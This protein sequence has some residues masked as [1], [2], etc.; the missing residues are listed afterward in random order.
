M[1]LVPSFVAASFAI[2]GL[3]A[4]AGP[5]II[6]L[7]N[8]RRYRIVHWAAMDFLREAL[9]RNRRILTLRDLLLLL[10]RTLAVLLVGLAL[11]RPFFSSS[12]QTY[13]RSK[14][15][16]AVLVVDNS[17]SMGY[18]SIEG[19]L[20]DR[21]KERARQF[22]DKLPADS[23][24]TI[25]P[26]CGS[27]SGYSPDAA[28]KENALQSLNKIELVDRSASVLRAMNE[29]KKACD[30][31]PTL[32][33]RIVIFSDQQIS[34]WRRLDSARSVP[35]DAADSGRGRFRDGPAEHVDLQLP[36]PRRRRGRR[37]ADDVP[38]R[39]PLRRHG[40]RADV[41]VQLSVDEQQVGSKTVTL[42]P[43]QG[44]REV[45]FQYLFNA[46]QPEPG[47]SLPVPVKVSLTPDNL[48]ADDE[49]CLVVPVVAALPVVFVDQF[50]EEEEDPVKNRLGE[51]R[52]LRKLLAPVASRTESPRQ[53]VRVRHVKLDQVTQELLED[54]R[55][56][57]VAGIADP[58]EKTPLLR[59]YVEQG[60]QLVIAAGGAYDPGRNSG[61]DPVRWNEAAW[62][63]GMGILPAPLL[64]EPLG[65]LPD[66]AAGDLKP[67]FLAF[68]SLQAHQFFQLAGVS[69]QELRDLYSEPF[70][71]K[72]V[73]AD[74]GNETLQALRQAEQKR[75][76]DEQEFIAQ[77]A[78]R[79]KQTV[80]AG[81]EAALN[82]AVKEQLRGDEQREGLLRHTWLLWSH[83]M[84]AG[85]EEA[86]PADAAQR[87]RR[88]QELAER[89]LPRVLARFDDPA[90]T[91]FL[92]AR[93]IQR[94]DVLFAT[95]GLLSN[96]N[97]LPTTNAVVIFDRTLRAM[98]QS[99]LPPRNFGPT[100]RI[101]LPLPTNE[102]EVTISL[103]RPD[104]GEQAE[105]LD[106]GFV[107]KDQLGFSI[108]QPL[109]R[110]FYRVTAVRQ[111]GN[112]GPVAKAAREVAW[113]LP[114]AVNGEA[115]ESELQ[116]LARDQFDARVGDAAVHWVGP[117]EEISLAGSQ[118]S[119]Q[120]S[121]W[122]LIL[123]VLGLLMVEL[124]LVAKW[125]A[126]ATNGPAPVP[127]TGT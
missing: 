115:D 28:T 76:A 4:A 33:P 23:R 95:S 27:R 90:G 52:L 127:A 19:T 72:A 38:G 29:A 67:F 98:I 96:W 103:R 109:A 92:L 99:T 42:E 62:L 36:R 126:R 77:A 123:T 81:G 87:E 44:A 45:S 46:Y 73:R 125:V 104:G 78:T 21:A 94:G 84:A 83:Q 105:L 111:N 80:E 82:E 113:E 97:T 35:G 41:E 122:W 66:E 2:A 85:D 88:L 25:I 86:L 60:G 68:D 58:G 57:V 13:D 59:D 22:I 5:I 100:E 7:L 17:L 6:H 56:V 119:G 121:W 37:N 8:R 124:L 18:E 69:E 1:N 20:L 91:P 114:L 65:A 15:L 79:R 40:A 11:A 118:V 108:E 101:T 71:F 89:T 70:F 14:P 112:G 74:V 120:D 110:G 116:L 10:L 61:F 49:R 3:I 32:G 9:Q 26:L 55:L 16:H 106:T 54:A 24:V 43:G 53:L 47:K 31:G 75:L 102:R 64:P 63:D 50:G 39:G 48:P 34:N 30:S 93:K 51:T 12:D 117:D 107:G